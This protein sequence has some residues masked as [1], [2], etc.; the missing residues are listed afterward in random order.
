M[1]RLY[2]PF[3]TMPGTQLEKYYTTH[4]ILPV[5]GHFNTPKA[6]HTADSVRVSTAKAACYI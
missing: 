4:Y 2:L 5:G 6:Q 3:V 1:C